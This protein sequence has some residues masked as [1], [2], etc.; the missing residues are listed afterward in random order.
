[1]GFSQ[2][3]PRGDGLGFDLAMQAAANISSW[4]PAQPEA[5]ALPPL[6]MLNDPTQ[7]FQLRLDLH[8]DETGIDRLLHQALSALGPEISDITVVG[9][10]LQDRRVHVNFSA[11]DDRTWMLTLQ[12]QLGPAEGVLSLR[13]LQI[14]NDSADQGALTQ[15]LHKLLSETRWPVNKLVTDLASAVVTGL[16]GE[17]LPGVFTEIELASIRPLDLKQTDGLLSLSVRINGK[18]AIRIR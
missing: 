13:I 15:T 4:K 12:P 3:K 6:G 5:S 10:Q 7:G 9:V 14:D 1:M 11:A 2:L 8:F 18:A 16:I 17:L